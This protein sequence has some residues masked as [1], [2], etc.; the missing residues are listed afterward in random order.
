MGTEG[1]AASWARSFTVALG[2][3]RPPVQISY[4]ETEPEGVPEHVGPV[5]SVCTFFAEGRER[6]F[7]A[8]LPAHEACEI[9]AFVLGIPAEGAVGERLRA[10]LG[11][12][13]AEGYLSPEE[14][15]RVPHNRRAP[16]FV[17]YG[18]LGS[19]P[20][21]PTVV[22][23]LVN[24][25]TTMLLLEAAGDPGPLLG[26]PMCSLVPVLLGGAPV[27]V[28]V[29]CTG[30]RLYG[31]LSDDLLIVG[32]RGDRTAAVADRL[33]TTVA[34]NRWLAEEDGRRREAVRPPSRRSAAPRRD[35]AAGP[36]S[37][38]GRAPAVARKR[39][40]GVSG[41]RPGSAPPPD[42]TRRR[43]GLRR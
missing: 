40:R 6:P 20:Y 21:E 39:P 37:P 34:A 36:A 27:A 1:G 30:S 42:R 22:L 24:P 4:L 12:M 32:L 33:A 2:L 16:R 41:S 19:L 3:D 29:G 5:P 13:A 26:R 11:R 28:S 25:K 18:P 23:F 31:R 14:A 38:P 8:A 43:R 10:T 7:Y 17:A 35:P 15:A 9:G